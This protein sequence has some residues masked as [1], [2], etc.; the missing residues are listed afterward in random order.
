[1][2][3][4]IIIAL[5]LFGLFSTITF[6]QEIVISKFNLKEIKIENNFILKDEEIKNLLVFIYNKNL[7]LLR[8]KEIE[9][10]LMRNDLIDSFKIKKRYPDK[11]IIKI[12][13]KKIIAIITSKKEKYYL[14]E[15]I[16]LIKFRQL[17]Y[18]RD[19]PYIIGNREK[20]KIFYNDLKKINFP[21]NIIKKYIFYE[22]NRWDIETIDNK[23]IKLPTKKY[24]ESL[25]NY[26]SLKNQINF[27]KFKVFDY[28]IENQLILK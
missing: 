14:S 25:E 3:K 11:L 4:R 13:E 2:K 9:Q 20:F 7:L 16:D 1:M 8:N 22:S 12:F 17:N 10:A 21:F 5:A 23:I 18:E 24:L 15:K 26:L 28:R 19:L 6:K 27:Q